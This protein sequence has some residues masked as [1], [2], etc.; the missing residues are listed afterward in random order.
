MVSS[1][2]RDAEIILVLVVVSMVGGHALGQPVFLS[3]VRTGSMSPTLAPGDGFVAIPAPVAGTPEPGDVVVYR[4]ERV[5]GGGLTTHRVVDVTERGYVT[6]GDANPFTDQAGGEPPVR[7]QRIV[8]VGLQVGGELVV[9]PELGTGVMTVRDAAGGAVR[10]VDG[11][12]G[13]GPVQFGL[14]FAFAAL[15]ALLLGE[16]AREGRRPVG[17]RGRNRDRS[18]GRAARW[19]V[20][21]AGLLVVGAATASMVL[22]LGP[23]TYEV[24]SAQADVPGPHVIPAGETESTTYALP[25]GELVPTRYYLQPASEGVEVTPE[26]V[27]VPPGETANATV[28]LS[29]PPRIGHYRRFVTERRYPLVLPRP[30]LDALYRLHWLAPVAVLDGLLAVPVWIAVRAVDRTRSSRTRAPGGVAS[31][32]DRLFGDGGRR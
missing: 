7:R 15:V 31:G 16:S 8:A 14:G 27:V 10:F 32:L 30:L 9:L 19:F 25:G 28:E 17:D 20:L 6:Q 4:A 24:V 13:F 3:Y 29:A 1:I 11:R 23:T 22:P 21:V 2:E 26:T 5:N 12:F 18:G